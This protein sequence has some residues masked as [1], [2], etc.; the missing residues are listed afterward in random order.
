MIKIVV[1]SHGGFCEGL[2][3][4]L[5]MVGGSDFGI[6]AVPLLPGEA[7]EDYREKLASCLDENAET[8]ILSDIAGGTPF[9]SALYLA[10]D[11]KLTVISGMNFP[12]LLTLA[13]ECNSG[14][15]RT[16]MELC[17]Q[18]TSEGNLGVEIKSII[19][20]E[21][22]NRAKLSVNKNR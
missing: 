1:V 2:L 3:D 6:K 19:K 14:E 21:K 7:P 22:R 15:E 18:A 12:M 17:K 4:T 13:F 11:F 8:I 10:K 16:V 20:G 5:K 9:Q